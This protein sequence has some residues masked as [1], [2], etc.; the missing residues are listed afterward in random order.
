[1]YA[2]AGLHNRQ[3]VTAVDHHNCPGLHV[4]DA[5]PCSVTGIACTP[6]KKFLL[7]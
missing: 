7:C 1:M 2:L 3:S 4:H 5:R 6:C